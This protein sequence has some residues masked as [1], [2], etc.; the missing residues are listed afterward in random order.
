MISSRYTP[1]IVLL[2]L[3][4]LVPTII[5]SYLK[6]KTDDRIVIKSILPDVKGYTSEPFTRHNAEW[7]KSMFDS[8]DWIERI[9]HPKDG[10]KIRLFITRSYNH[11]RLYHHPELGLSHGNDLKKEGIVFL[12]EERSI[13]VH[14]LRNSSG[15]GLVAYALLYDGQ[16]ID[17]PVSHQLQDSLRQLVSASRPMTLFYVSDITTPAS[18]DFSQTSAALVLKTAIAGFNLETRSQVAGNQ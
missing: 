6:A 15:L 12:G 14:L 18:V 9:Y 8:E 17:N 13:P 4:A 10:K 16:F 1:S 2:L 3:L 7:V 11:K 5:H